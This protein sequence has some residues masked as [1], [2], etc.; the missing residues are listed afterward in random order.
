MEVKPWGW[1]GVGCLAGPGTSGQAQ[2]ASDHAIL[3]LN[4]HVLSKRIE[5]L[6]LR[7]AECLCKASGRKGTRARGYQVLREL[8]LW[9]TAQPGRRKS[10]WDQEST[11]QQTSESQ[12]R[13]LPFSRWGLPS[14]QST[15]FLSPGQILIEFLLCACALNTRQ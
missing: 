5:C 15:V 1:I 9:L 7:P 11:G 2:G 4:K 10:R 12:A 6:G 14:P 3:A 13:S 8:G